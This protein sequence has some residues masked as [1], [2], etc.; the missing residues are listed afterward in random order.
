M[1]VIHCPCLAFIKY[2]AFIIKHNIIFF[3]SPVC[4]ALI[5]T[6]ISAKSPERDSDESDDVGGVDMD[7]ESTDD[8]ASEEEGASNHG[9]SAAD[10]RGLL[11]G[12]AERGWLDHDRVMLE[13]LMAFKRAGCDGVLTYFAP[14]AARI[15]NG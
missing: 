6:K 8:A 4:P 1:P 14:A 5:K 11:A 2:L 10:L 15:L 12:A 9:Q 7:N 3:C 13:S